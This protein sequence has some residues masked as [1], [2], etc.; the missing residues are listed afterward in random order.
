MKSPF[1]PL[2]VACVIVLSSLGSAMADK[3]SD[4]YT[5]YQKAESAHDYETI[6]KITLPAD[7][8]IFKQKVVEAY[9]RGKAEL[10]TKEETRSLSVTTFPDIETLEKMRPEDVYLTFRKRLA[11]PEGEPRVEYKYAGYRKVGDVGVIDLTFQPP[12]GGAEKKA[13][14]YIS[15]ADGEIFLRLPDSVFADL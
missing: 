5:S 3:Y 6:T 13:L 11:P 15:E 14:I 9:K 7:L 10:S 1:L 2:A 12:G 8:D 4:F